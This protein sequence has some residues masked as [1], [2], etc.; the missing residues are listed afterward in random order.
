[1]WESGVEEKLT[2]EGPVGIGS[3]GRRVGT[4]MGGD[5]LVW[6][7]TEWKPSEPAAY[8]FESDKIIGGGEYTT[9]PTDS[10][11]RLTYRFEAGTKNPFFELLMPFFTPMVNRKTKKGYQKLKE[12]LDP[13]RRARLSRNMPGCTLSLAATPPTVVPLQ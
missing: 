5:E 4:F 6:E 10:G 11:T 7:V 2:S 12:V 1:M 8:R 9:D 13:D 3:K